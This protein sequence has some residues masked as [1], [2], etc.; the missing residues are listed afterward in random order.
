M[1]KIFKTTVFIL[2]ILPMLSAQED[3]LLLTKNFNF[4]DG[5]YMTFED[6]QRNKPTYKWDELRSN[7]V[8][9]PKTFLAQVEFLKIKE[10]DSLINLE[11]VWGIS[12]GGL[13]YIRLEKGA[14]KKE[15]TSFAAL[16]VR[17]KICYFEYEDFE[18]VQIPMPVYNPVTGRPFRV[19]TVERK[20]NVYY[21]KI[22][23]FETGR[24]EFL[25]VDNLKSW[26]EED[27]QLTKALQSL[28]DDADEKLFKCILIY[29]DRHKVYIQE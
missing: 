25:T 4:H 17:G 19:A 27:T 18:V 26:V 6:F 22:L 29:D 8:A 11:H 9:N 3:S 14:V 28:G 2:C 13:P 24:I 21:E 10:L 23:D 1:I 12:I 7:L 15:L 16:R 20:I 5:V